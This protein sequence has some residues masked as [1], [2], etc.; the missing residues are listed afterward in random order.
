MLSINI[1]IRNRLWNR[2]NTKENTG[3]EEIHIARVIIHMVDMFARG[4]VDLR[5]VYHLRYDLLAKNASLHTKHL[6]MMFF[7]A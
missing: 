6:K 5:N 2:L 7:F 3:S 4:D 1:F